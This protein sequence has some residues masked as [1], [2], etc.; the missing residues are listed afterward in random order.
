MMNQTDSDRVHELCSRIAT[1]QNN[2]KFLKLVEELNY[3]LE[4]NRPPPQKQSD[5]I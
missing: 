4:V 5:D 3:L 2:Q 1:E